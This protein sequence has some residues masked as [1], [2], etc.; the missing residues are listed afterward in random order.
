MKKIISLFLVILLLSLN[1]TTIKL[2]KSDRRFGLSGNHKGAQIEMITKD[3][4]HI[5]GELIAIKRDSILLL[6]QDTKMDVTIVI[7]DIKIVRL[8][9]KTSVLSSAGIGFLSGVAFGTVVGVGIYNEGSSWLDD[10]RENIIGGAL[11]LGITGVIIGGLAGIVSGIDETIQIEGKSDS[12][13]IEI[14]RKL[15]GKARI[16]N[17]K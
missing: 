2:K 13:I 8:V 10:A 3:D 7:K 4:Q 14:L 1:C 5:R 16:K 12:E 9:K 6:E 17:A 15:R 11:F